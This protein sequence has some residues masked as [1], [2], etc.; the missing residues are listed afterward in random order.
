LEKSY[1][2]RG[3]RVMGVSEV[4]MEDRDDIALVGKAHKKHGMDY[5][6]LLDNDFAW[7]KS[8]GLAGIPSFMLID[9]KG[10]IVLVY[11][12]KLTVGSE[13]YKKLDARIG[14]LLGG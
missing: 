8:A 2:A 1:A 5:P 14:A 3:L 12:G 6:C 4:D 7:A 13:A 10:K 11:R 9:G